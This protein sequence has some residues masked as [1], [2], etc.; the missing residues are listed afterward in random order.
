[1]IEKIYYD[2][3]SL[4]IAVYN[5]IVHVQLETLSQLLL[6]TARVYCLDTISLYV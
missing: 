3:S 1:M 4:K 2:F 5:R 6:L